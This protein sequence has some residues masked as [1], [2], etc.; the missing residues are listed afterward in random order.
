MTFPDMW[1]VAWCPD[2]LEPI[3]Q[4]AST[5]HIPHEFQVNLVRHDSDKDRPVLVLKNHRTLHGEGLSIS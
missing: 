3:K 2:R 1:D 4:F 5:S